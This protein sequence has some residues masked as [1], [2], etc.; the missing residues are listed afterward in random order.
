M[1]HLLILRNTFVSILDKLLT[2]FMSKNDIYNH[3]FI[4]FYHRFKPHQ[5]IKKNEFSTM[6]FLVRKN[7]MC[8]FISL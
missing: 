7:K 8:V 6:R 1:E 2:M 3:H 5:M 4:T